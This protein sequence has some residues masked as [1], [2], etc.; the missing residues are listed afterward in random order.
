MQLI[1]PG[2]NIPPLRPNLTDEYLWE[3]TTQRVW[4]SFLFFCLRLRRPGLTSSAALTLQGCCAP[5]SAV[6]SLLPRL[7][8]AQRMMLYNLQ[9][10]LI[11]STSLAI[12]RRLTDDLIL[13]FSLYGVR[14]N[15]AQTKNRESGWERGPEVA[16]SVCVK[17]LIIDIS[18]LIAFNY[19]SSTQ[20]P[21]HIPPQPPRNL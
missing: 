3:L 8:L 7:F 5:F 20:D 21:M 15:P 11:W 10:S 2:K 4:T 9:R 6:L 1:G 14:W 12:Y 13:A 17:W 18:A 19:R 16:Q